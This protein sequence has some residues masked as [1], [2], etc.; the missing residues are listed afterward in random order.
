MSTPLLPNEL[1]IQQRCIRGIVNVHGKQIELSSLL[2][3][4]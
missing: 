2:T 1:V 3:L 4:V